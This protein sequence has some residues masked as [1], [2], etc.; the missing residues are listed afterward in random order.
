M[1]NTGREFLGP[2]RRVGWFPPAGC[3]DRELRPVSSSRR[4]SISRA[5]LDGRVNPL[6]FVGGW[7]IVGYE[8]RPTTFEVPGLKGTE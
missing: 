5:L 8:V 2:S 6:C 4:S 1:G 3:T 7:W